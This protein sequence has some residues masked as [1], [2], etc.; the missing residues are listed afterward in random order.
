MAQHYLQ[1]VGRIGGGLN[2]N[3]TNITV[4]HIS[5][6]TAY[7]TLKHVPSATTITAIFST[8]N[9]NSSIL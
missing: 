4:R 6:H 1:L 2:I 3:I 7:I 9:I 8:L 5:Y